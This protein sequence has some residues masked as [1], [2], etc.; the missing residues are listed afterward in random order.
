MNPT[1]N[2]G[3]GVVRWTEISDADPSG[4]QIVSSASGRGYKYSD[5]SAV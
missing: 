1:E 5:T 2:Y 4:A 3:K